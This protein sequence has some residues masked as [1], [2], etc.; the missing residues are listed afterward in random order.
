MLARLGYKNDFRRFK[1]LR[2][3]AL[4]SAL[5]IKSGTLPMY[6]SSSVRN[7]FLVMASGP[8][9]DVY[10]FSLF[11]SALISAPLNSSSKFGPST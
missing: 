5:L 9:A 8:G 3:V 11:K 6:L 10:V 7:V 1:L 2:L 4:S